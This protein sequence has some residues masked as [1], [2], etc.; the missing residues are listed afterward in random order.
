MPQFMNLILSV[1]EKKIN[2]YDYKIICKKLA[3]PADFF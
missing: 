3:N 2:N 1:L